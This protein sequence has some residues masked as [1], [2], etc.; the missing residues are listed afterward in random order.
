MYIIQLKIKSKSKQALTNFLSFFQKIIKYQNFFI[1]NLKASN[2]NCNNKKITILTSP[3]VYKNAQEHFY[4]KQYS[5][6]I[7]IFSFQNT[8]L[9]IIIKKINLILFPE[10]S[11]QIRIL[12]T[13]TKHK[14]I[15]SEII[16]PEMYKTKI[17]NI[18][19]INTQVRKSRKRLISINSK[20][21]L[22]IK[23]LFT[24]FHLQLR[25]Q[26]LQKKKYKTLKKPFYDKKININ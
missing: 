8:K 25:H 4:I 20:K 15:I 19:T 12:L 24:Q 22:P 6:K 5:K 3:H 11:I 23:T 9:L 10:I 21:R 18:K 17:N 1:L 16:N 14:K 26:I 7:N 2:C 13:K